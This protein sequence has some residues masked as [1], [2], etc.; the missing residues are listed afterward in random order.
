MESYPPFLWYSGAI[1]TT[2]KN[3]PLIKQVVKLLDVHVTSI[4]NKKFT[5]S[6]NPKHQKGRYRYRY[7]YRSVC[8]KSSCCVL[9]LYIHFIIHIYIY[10]YIYIRLRWSRGSLL[11]FSTQVRGFKPG[12]SRRIFMA[13]KSSARL[14]S[15]GK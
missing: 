9:V 5:R 14:P 11:A 4:R 3:S 1:L 13:K 8:T 6:F 2:L 7:I 10:I 12:R 15:E